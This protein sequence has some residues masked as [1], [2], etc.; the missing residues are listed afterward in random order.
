[1]TDTKF[2]PTILGLALLAAAGCD[3]TMQAREP[4]SAQVPAEPV[5]AAADKPAAVAAPAD[6]P[7]VVH[8]Y[9]Q[10]YSGCFAERV[11]ATDRETCK[12]NCGVL[13]T[14]AREALPGAP[15]QDVLDK[16]LASLAGCVNACYD[17]GSLSETNR[18]TC[19][20][21]CRDVADVAAGSP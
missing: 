15:P 10:C 8:D 9:G 6:L 12:L 4:A 16:R 20:L 17:D 3:E 13:A 2:M 18:E 7:A 5:Q 21:T 14:A 1:M 11:R 19:L